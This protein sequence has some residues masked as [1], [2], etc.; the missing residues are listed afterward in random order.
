MTSPSPGNCPISPLPSPNPIADQFP[1]R[2][3]S[4]TPPPLSSARRRSLPSPTKSSDHEHSTPPFASVKLRYSSSPRTRQ[5]SNPSLKETTFVQSPSA[6]LSSMV[7]LTIF[8]SDSI[9]HHSRT[10]LQ[11][12]APL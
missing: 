9:V 5:S 12:S 3:L 10:V 6:C 2:S 7:L 11:H 1:N 4:A 8:V